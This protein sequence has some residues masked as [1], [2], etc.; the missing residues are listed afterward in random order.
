MRL[1]EI[2]EPGSFLNYLDKEK[3]CI[4]EKQNTRTKKRTL[5]RNLSKLWVFINEEFTQSSEIEKRQ[6]N[7]IILHSSTKMAS[8]AAAA[9]SRGLLGCGT[10]RYGLFFT[11][12]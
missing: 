6:Y 1:K 11:L 5:E 9:F 10:L 4:C 8:S 12:S 3:Q 7:L 2:I